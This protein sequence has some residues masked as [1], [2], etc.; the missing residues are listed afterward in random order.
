MNGPVTNG[1][2]LAQAAL[3][4][5]V[6]LG[7]GALSAWTESLG[8][9]LAGVVLA[10]LL[11]TFFL[12]RSG[13]SWRDMGL[14]RPAS[15]GKALLAAVLAYVAMV[16]AVGVIVPL[17]LSAFGLERPELSA[18]AG[19]EGNLPLLLLF[20]GPIA[21][22][23]AAFGEEMIARG[24]LLDRLS[25]VFA[26]ERR[27]WGTGLVLQAIFFGVAHAY[28]GIPGIVSTAVVGLIL[29][30]AYLRV[31]RNLWPV[32]IA[33]GVADTIALVAIYLGA[34]PTS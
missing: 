25:I 34:L 16:A 19:I 1:S 32:I 17:A 21:W 12:R 23:T 33:H 24:F 13:E 29:G 27:A 9:G 7:G 22:G 6:I 31:E 2:V 5:A 4:L 28:Q 20:L 11:A 8:Y 26:G 3:V 18:F 15:W 10:L 14:R 30:F